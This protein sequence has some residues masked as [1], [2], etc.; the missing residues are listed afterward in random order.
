MAI[1]CYIVTSPRTLNLTQKRKKR[2]KSAKIA[3]PKAC[4]GIVF[5]ALNGSENNH[6][7]AAHVSAQTTTPKPVTTSKSPKVGDATFVFGSMVLKKQ[8][9]C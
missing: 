4:G 9:H 5:L 2:P 1:P 7:I 6:L 8:L 3:T